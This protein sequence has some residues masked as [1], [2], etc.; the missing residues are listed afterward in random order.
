[1]T[2]AKKK[3]IPQKKNERKK[4][5]MKYNTNGKNDDFLVHGTHF[6]YY[7]RRVL[8][9]RLIRTSFSSFFFYLFNFDK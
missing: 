7:M 5:Y 4:K 8:I 9:A 3:K 2:Q 1:M 6:L